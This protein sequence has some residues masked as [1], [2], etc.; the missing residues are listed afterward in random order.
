MDHL[1]Y[2]APARLRA[3]FGC[4]TEDDWRSDD[5]QVWELSYG[6][7]DHCPEWVENRGALLAVWVADHPGTRPP[8]WWRL[9]SPEERPEGESQAAYLRR[10]KLLLR[11]EERRLTP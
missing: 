1:P 4:A 5:W 6:D 9:D 2:I 7:R 3:M 11:G 10:H 8:I